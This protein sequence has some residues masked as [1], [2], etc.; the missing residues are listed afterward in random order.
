VGVEFS[1]F[2]RNFE[3]KEFHRRC[4]TAHVDRDGKP[5]SFTGKFARS[6]AAGGT[7]QTP[8]D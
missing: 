3:L 2:A 5:L 6:P 7:P 4:T 1:Q 8:T